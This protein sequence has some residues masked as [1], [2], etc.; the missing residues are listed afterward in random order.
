MISRLPIE[1]AAFIVRQGGIIAYPT[2][3]VFGLGCDPRNESAVRRLLAIKRRPVTKGVILVAADLEQLKLFIDP[4][5]PDYL[6][7]VQ[8]TWPGPVTWLVPARYK[9]PPWLRGRHPTLAV[10]VTAHPVAAA[11]CQA[12]GTPLV[13]TSANLSGQPPARTAQQVRRRLGGLLDYIVPG[14]TGG[15]LRPTEIRD[16]KS[17]QV[18]RAGS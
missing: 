16:L 18:V 1:R 7:Q 11:L 14:A 2:E 8:A 10:R 6:A 4:L 17:G 15:A 5:D 12:C 9:T 3:A 13:S